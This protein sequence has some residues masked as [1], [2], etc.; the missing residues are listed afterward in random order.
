VGATGLGLL[1]EEH[2]GDIAAAWRLAVEGE[3][4]IR[5]PALAFAVAPLL[6]EAA[7]ALGGAGDPRRPSRDAWTRCAVLVRSSASPAQL[8]REFKVLHRAIWDALRARGVPV[9]PGDRAAADEWLQEALAE[10]L[11]RLERVRL[12]ASALEKA[13]SPLPPIVRAKPPPLPARPPPVARAGARTAEQQPIEL[14]PL[15]HL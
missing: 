2:R 11:D 13:S 10:A 14:E 5:D 3:L 15:P 9:S 12:R 8:A 6:R 4:G 7:L 1:L